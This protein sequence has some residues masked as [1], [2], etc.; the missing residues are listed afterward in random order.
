MCS[1]G[2]MD[3]LSVNRVWRVNVSS[4]KLNGIRLLRQLINCV[5]ELRESS[6]CLSLSW[7]CFRHCVEL[8]VWNRLFIVQSIIKVVNYV[9]AW[10]FVSNSSMYYTLV[11]LM[12][13]L[14]M[15]HY[16][17]LHRRQI[18]I[19]PLVPSFHN[20]KSILKSHEDEW[21]IAVE[22]LYIHRCK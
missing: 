1:G 14:S 16:F 10:V 13:R 11:R 19:S 9:L 2:L 20:K 5:F 17:Y 6:S 21:Y 15:T 18:C 4:W 8:S 22:N 3:R 7:C 12:L